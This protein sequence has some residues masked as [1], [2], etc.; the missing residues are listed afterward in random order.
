MFLKVLERRNPEFVK[1]VVEFHQK[2]E[3]KP[4]TFVIDLDVVTEN[5]KIIKEEAD[6]YGLDIYWMTK[7]I[8]RNPVILKM[9]AEIGS[10]KTIA[11]DIEGARIIADNGGVVAHLGHLS[12]VPRCDIPWVLD[13]NPEIIT[14]YSVQKAQDIGNIA[15]QKGKVQ[16]IMLR[17]V[18]DD[19]FFYPG[20]TGGIH[21]KDLL[22][23]IKQLQKIE[24]INLAG[25]TNF[26]CMLYDAKK[27]Q[28]LPC[29]NM[30]TL[31]EAVK[32]IK[33]KTNVILKQINT[34][35]T[36]STEII[37]TLAKAGATHIEPG[38]GLTGTTPIS[39]VKDLPERPGILYVTEV[40]HLMG[41][42]AYIFGGGLWIDPVFPPYQLM[43]LVHR[44]PDAIF[45]QKV[46]AKVAPYELID[47]YGDLMPEAGQDVR[48]NDTV[49]LAYRPQVFVTRSLTAVIS[50]VQEGHPRVVGVFDRTGRQI[51]R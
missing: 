3:L 21:I 8:N 30:R 7:Q 41:D 33:E 15:R 22:D 26:P 42:K 24:G 37:E 50:G 34:P 17:V 10:P 27:K 40:S 5:A 2:G 9:L 43:A 18:D 14:V 4:N 25:V 49:I 46:K 23:V 31:F 28:V 45:T 6:K 1:A 16:D 47:Y 20:Q 51:S 39:V 19:N 36:T 29:N 38:H 48:I 44:D 13:L 32:L 11:V 35:G 12:Q